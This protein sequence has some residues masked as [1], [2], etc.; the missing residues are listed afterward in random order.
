[1]YC[2][3]GD[4]GLLA[5]HGFVVLGVG[6]QPLQLVQGVPPIQHPAKHR[7]LQI[8]N[9]MTA[10]TIQANAMGAYVITYRAL[11]A[12]LHFP[13]QVFL[14]RIYLTRSKYRKSIFISTVPVHF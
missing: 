8:C 4:P 7:V 13:S 10:L 6:L 3:A 14:T 2:D 11:L 5:R 12:T 1:M 9:K